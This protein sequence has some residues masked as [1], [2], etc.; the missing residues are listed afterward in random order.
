MTYNQLQEKLEKKDIAPGYLFVGKEEFLKQRATKR[1]SSL[2]SARRITINP[3]NEKE[4]NN[5]LSQSL[6]FGRRLILIED[7]TLFS[8]E[9][10]EQI[11]KYIKRPESSTIILLEKERNPNLEKIVAQHGDV[12]IFPHL[13]GKS[14]ILWAKGL[15][16]K[17]GKKV[18]EETLA[19]L[20]NIVGD[21]LSLLAAEIEKLI[22]FCKEKENVTEEDVVFLVSGGSS[23][24][25]FKFFELVKMGDR[26]AINICL[27]L[28][29]G[30]MSASHILFFL[31]NRMRREKPKK[32]VFGFLAETD[33]SLKREP[34]PSYT[35]IILSL[36]LKILL[37][38]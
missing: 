17:E 24:D 38:R 20:L 3:Q 18:D 12:V 8:K 25:N 34:K 13:R 6:I 37:K 28:I 22:L 23:Q 19:T 11:L 7:A 21:D 30:G 14:L 9:N 15:F 36:L 29:E 4:L 32:E 2:L 31:A 26:K 16:D 33:L 27:Q 5:I 1:L 35:L 10:K